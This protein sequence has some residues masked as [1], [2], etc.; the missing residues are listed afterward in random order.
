MSAISKAERV[1]LR[2]DMSTVAALKRDVDAIQDRA[3]KS[4]AIGAITLN[5]AR[6]HS[7]RQADAGRNYYV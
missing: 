7:D 2:Y 3:R 6:R 4:F 5:E 1:R